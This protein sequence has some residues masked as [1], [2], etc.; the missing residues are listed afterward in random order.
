MAHTKEKSTTVVCFG[1]LDGLLEQLQQYAQTPNGEPVCLYG[2]LAYP[3]RVHLQAPFRG[4]L[5]PWQEEFSSQTSKV[6]ISVEWLFNEIIQ[7]FAFLDF[8]K[9]LKIRL[10]LVGKMYRVH[11]IPTNVRTSLCKTQTSEYFNI[12]PPTLEEYFT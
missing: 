6:R 11:A 1:I 3:S 5:N 8:K 9:N 10:S 12:N 7:Y 2:E 4:N